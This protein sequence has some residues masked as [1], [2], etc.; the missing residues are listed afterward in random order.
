MATRNDVFNEYVRGL[1]AKH[2]SY[3][4]IARAYPDAN[5]TMMSSIANGHR[6][7]GY[8]AARRYEEIFGL[9]PLYFEDL[10]DVTHVPLI[11]WSDIMSDDPTPLEQIP[12][13]HTEGSIFALRVFGDEL[14]PDFGD[15][16]VIFVKR[17]T[18]ADVQPNNAMLLLGDGSLVRKKLKHD[19]TYDL[20]CEP[21][22]VVISRQ[23]TFLYK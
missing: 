13:T 17:D 6:T 15:G 2:K 5:P 20:P 16:D 11:A 19:G 4:G 12:Y 21:I 3:A 23:V 10:P 1:L 22:G 14:L 9:H 18:N 8:R 7:L